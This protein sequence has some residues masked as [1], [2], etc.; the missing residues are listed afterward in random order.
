MKKSLFVIGIDGK[1]LKKSIS[2]HCASD[3]NANCWLS[4]LMSTFLNSTIYDLIN[5][6]FYDCTFTL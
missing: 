4:H 5:Y 2:L 3:N 6:L 1:A